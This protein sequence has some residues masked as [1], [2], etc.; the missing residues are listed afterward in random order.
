MGTRRL[1]NSGSHNGEQSRNVKVGSVRQDIIHNDAQ[2]AATWFTSKRY[3][4]VRTKPSSGEDGE[5][6]NASEPLG[7]LNSYSSLYERWCKL[8][9]ERWYKETTCCETICLQNCRRIHTTE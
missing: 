2:H 7:S 5:T 9:R 4:A 6:A 8:D 1:D 3:D